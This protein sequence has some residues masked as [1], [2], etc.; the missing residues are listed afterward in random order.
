LLRSPWRTILLVTILMSAFRPVAITTMP[1]AIATAAIAATCIATTLTI[2]S[3]LRPVTALR[4]G[5]L[6]G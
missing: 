1:V 4:A 5:A 6:R 3:A 2:R